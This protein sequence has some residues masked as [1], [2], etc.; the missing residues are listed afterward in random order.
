MGALGVGLFL[1]LGLLR[2]LRKLE[3]VRLV[4]YIGLIRLIGLLED[5]LALLI[6]VFLLDNVLLLMRRMS[7]SISFRRKML[8]N[9]RFELGNLRNLSS[10]L[11][12]HHVKRTFFF[13]FILN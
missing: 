7:D 8:G 5:R 12:R 13:L 11:Y 10:N 4:G 9:F 6:L 2:G 3:S 1:G